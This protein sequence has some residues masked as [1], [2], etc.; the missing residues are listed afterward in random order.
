[1]SSQPPDWQRYLLTT[2]KVMAII[3]GVLILLFGICVAYVRVSLG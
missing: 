2:L 3:V 1:M